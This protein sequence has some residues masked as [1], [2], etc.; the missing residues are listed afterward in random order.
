M[1][2]WVDDPD[3]I[4][5]A[6]GTTCFIGVDGWDPLSLSDPAIPGSG[7]FLRNG[8]ASDP[9]FGYA[10]YP[11][12]GPNL[13]PNPLFKDLMDYTDGTAGNSER[14]WISDVTFTNIFLYNKVVNP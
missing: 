5:R 13:M 14:R 9:R 6:F 4:S 10:D 7:A 3:Y 12:L 1:A 2:Q 8:T 11:L